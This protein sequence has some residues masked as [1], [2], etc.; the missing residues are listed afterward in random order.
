MPYSFRPPRIPDVL[1]LIQFFIELCLLRRAPQDLPASAALFGLA[2]AADLLISL[3]LAAIAGLP[4][5]LGLVEGLTD[6]LFMLALLYG[7]LR[8]LNRPARFAQA[9][10]A[11]L[12]S[13]AVLGV[14]A[15][16]PIS[17][18]PSG[19]QADPP[20]IAALML[21]ALVIWSVLVTGHILR[22]TFDLRL[23]QGIAIAVVYNMLAFSLVR[24]IFTGS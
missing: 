17:M 10:T 2:L 14:L 15:L 21:L 7:A 6:V 5:S 8:M 4:L 23:G 1:T 13:G 19:E 24:G 9:A 20:A 12:G 11:L 18:L 22:H 3:M 16:L